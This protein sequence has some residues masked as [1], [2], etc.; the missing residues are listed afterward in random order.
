MRMYPSCSSNADVFVEAHI[1]EDL[2]VNQYWDVRSDVT[3][4]FSA[5]SAWK[6]N[7][8]YFG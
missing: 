1:G 8:I 3:L 7:W 5:S 2:T 4:C 6:R